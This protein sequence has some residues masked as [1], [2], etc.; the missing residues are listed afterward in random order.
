M[1]EETSARADAR[2]ETAPHDGEESVDFAV[3]GM[4]CAS[5]AAVIEK[6][7]AKTEGVDSA[8]VNL[9]AERLRVTFD[10]TRIDIDEIVS[11]VESAGYGATS[12]SKAV[13]SPATGH[14]DL[15]VT[16]MTCASCSAVIEKSL[17][18]VDGVSAAVV[19]LARESASVDFDPVIVG[20]EEIISAVIAAGYGAELKT[21][22]VVG[23]GVEADAQSAAQRA[24]YQHQR[25]LLV[26]SA[27]LSIPLLFV[28]MVPPFM[29]AIPTWIASIFGISGESGVMMVHK[30]IMLVLATPVQFYAGAQYYRGFWHAL[31]RRT[32]NM[33]TL[34]AIG[35]TAAF[36]YSVAATFW[37]TEQPAFY[38]TSALLITFVL[39]GKMLEAR[40][41]GRTGDAIKKLM[42]LAAKTARVVRGGEELDVAVEQVVVGD[43]VI[44]RPG[45]KVP[46]D[47]VLTEGGSS[48]DES[49]LTGESIPVEKNPG[50]TV[51][52]A[53]LNKLGSFRMRATKVGRDTAL[54]QIIRLVEEAQGSKAPVQRFAD[55][56]SAVFV[57][58]VVGTALATFLFWLIAGPVIFGAAPDPAAYATVLHP[59]LRAAAGSGWFVA[60]L[61]AGTAAVVIACPCALGLATPTAIMVGTG[62]GAE[63]GVLIKSGEALETAYRI[64]AIVFDKTGTLTH[65]QPKVTDVV[66]LDSE[67]PTRILELAASLERSSEHPLAEAIVGHAN[68]TGVAVHPVISFSAIPGH[69]V[70][71]EVDGT[72]VVLGNRKLMER[73]ALACD[74]CE[75][76]IA[77]LESQGKTVMI[78]G[79]SGVR[80]VGLI[81]VA[82]TLKEH[83]KPAVARL[84]EMGVEVYMITG[85]N[86]TTAQAVALQAGISSDHVLA[87]VL[88]EDKATRVAALQSQGLRTAM[89]G[90]GINDTP[91]LAQADVG[92]AMGAG[93]DV[94]METGG[95]VLIKN[96]LRDVVTAIELSR[97][98]MRKIK[99][100][101]VWALGYNTL[102]IPVAAIGLLSQFPWLAGAAMAF[103]SVSV[104]TNSLLLRRFRPSMR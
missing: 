83:S 68:D 72:R 31:K 47:G 13:A 63:N 97:A 22:S 5:C 11:Q 4:T 1:S 69:G 19:N 85:D 94:A 50:D 75:R 39:L 84:R 41:K 32:G 48:V 17:D 51:I 79:I 25:N 64:D 37:I 23:A 24:F 70:A 15:V 98:T 12:M 46:V 61:L 58:A 57:P 29:E 99:S 101:F 89:V 14:V 34:V 91:A 40:A 65:G 45:E 44:V 8:A 77:E 71:G 96:D 7:L 53:T 100:N 102:G 73:E 33:D 6:T 10:P 66:A 103:S 74:S 90:D 93:T 59:I 87:E 2:D 9:A 42:G 81:A 52:G 35:T 21:E 62:K 60:A 27:T 43:I 55:R 80:P 104:V 88:P 67:D 49:M 36:A 3:T 54:A 18:K 76:E 86:R 16:G 56:I 92:I 95:I 38:E 20:P 82:D 78:V 30:Y 26:F 28:A